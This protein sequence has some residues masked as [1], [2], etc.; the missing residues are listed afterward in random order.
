MSGALAAGVQLL[1]PS[2]SGTFMSGRAYFRLADPA[3]FF[4]SC[5]TLTTQQPAFIYKIMFSSISVCTIYRV[6]F[7][8]SFLCETGPPCA[9]S[10][11]H[12]LARRSCIKDG[13]RLGVKCLPCMVMLGQGMVLVPAVLSGLY[14][15]KV[16]HAHVKNGPVRNSSVLCP[17]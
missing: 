17:K 9:D 10:V 1:G 6:G 5:V 12:P 13:K 16:A 15:P 8:T 2:S 7:Q 14:A 3:G 4:L 11:Q